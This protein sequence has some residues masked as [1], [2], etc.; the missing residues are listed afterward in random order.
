MKLRISLVYVVIG[1]VCFQ[2]ILRLT[3]KIVLTG[4]GGI[5]A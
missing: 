2:K 4:V 1:A 3:G 5:V